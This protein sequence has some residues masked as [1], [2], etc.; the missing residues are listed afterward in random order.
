M[1]KDGKKG[2]KGKKKGK[3]KKD[4]KMKE[5]KI[6]PFDFI[7]LVRSDPE[8][9]DEFCYLQRC[10]EPYDYMVKEFDYQREEYMTISSRGITYFNEGD[11]TFLTLD[12]WEREFTLYQKLR[13]IEFFAKYK[14]WKNFL[15]WKRLMRINKMKTY[16][17]SLHRELFMLDD[18]LRLPLLEI[19]QACLTP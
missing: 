12:E 1:A 15:L 17:A 9:A 6:T 7:Q 3:D 13:E 2:G 16:Q 4:S 18:Q 11:G 8:M 10:G 19:R 14:I 5:Q